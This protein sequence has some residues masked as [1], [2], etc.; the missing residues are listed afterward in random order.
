MYILFWMYFITILT[1]FSLLIT[2][3]KSEYNNKYIGF[4]MINDC[5]IY[6]VYIFS[7]KV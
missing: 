7:L 4:T 5:K 3:L 6:L 1:L 2:N